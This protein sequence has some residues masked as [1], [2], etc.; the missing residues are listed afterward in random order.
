VVDEGLDFGSGELIGGRNPER[1][2]VDVANGRQLVH[3]NGGDVGGAGETHR[4][5]RVMSLPR[6]SGRRRDRRGLGIGAPV[7]GFVLMGGWLLLA[8]RTLRR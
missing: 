4:G 1:R 6:R 5:L 8:L 7:G 3:D 2:G